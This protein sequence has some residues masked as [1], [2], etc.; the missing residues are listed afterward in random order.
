MIRVHNSTKESTFLALNQI[1]LDSALGVNGSVLIKIN[2]AA[3]PKRGHPRTDPTLLKYVIEYL[4][5]YSANCAI[6]EGADGYLQQNI[7][8]TGLERLI[9]DRC[10]TLIDIDSEESE[11]VE[12]NGEIHYLPVC[13]KEFPIRIGIPVTTKRPGLVFSNNVKLFLGIVPRRFYQNG[14]L[15]VPRPALHI[16]LH[17]SIANVYQ[18]LMTYAPFNYFI[19]GGIGL[20]ERNRDFFIRHIYAG[21][22][23]VDL[24]QLVL[25]DLNI[26]TPEYIKLL[27]RVK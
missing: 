22:N 13:L 21:N 9:N 3:P 18:A 23:A 27:N 15:R 8:C 7:A 2:M 20:I 17:K 4:F 11:R 25:K 26:E 12:V 16:N 1:G 14:D 5:N 24:D 19:N 10:I 6:V